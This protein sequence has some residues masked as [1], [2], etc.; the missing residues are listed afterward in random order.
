MSEV[1]IHDSEFSCSVFDGPEVS[2]EGT[3]MASSYPEAARILVRNMEAKHC[4]YPV[5]AG[6]KDAEVIVTGKGGAKTIR[7]F[8]VPCYDSEEMGENND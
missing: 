4:E 3:V 2:F 5:A 1:A 7:V 8:G 6:L